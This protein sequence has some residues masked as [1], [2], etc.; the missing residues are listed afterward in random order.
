MYL[1][2]V[3]ITERDTFMSEYDKFPESAE[4]YWEKWVDVYE[5]EMDALEEEILRQELLEQELEELDDGY[6]AYNDEPE[7]AP[8]NKIKT[9][10]TPFGVLPLTE[11]TLASTHFKFW[12]GHTNFRLLKKHVL[13][14]ENVIGVETVDV[15]TP[16]R[17]RISVAK[18][19][20]DRDVMSSVRAVLIK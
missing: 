16:Y 18:L 20:K 12:V 11:Q 4:V 7:L 2:M 15:M 1:E 13:M 5:Q 14:I 9:I 3:N 19:F 10:L 8:F 17:F 6:S